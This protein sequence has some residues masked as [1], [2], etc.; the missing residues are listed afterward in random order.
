MFTILETDEDEPSDDSSTEWLGDVGGCS[1]EQVRSQVD[2]GHDIAARLKKSRAFHGSPLD[3]MLTEKAMNKAVKW[4]DC[5]EDAEQRADM[6]TQRAIEWAQRIEAEALAKA[7]G[8]PWRRDKGSTS[9]FRGPP[10][11]SAD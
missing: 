9:H 4:A 8:V 3:E 1:E 11:G 7:A 10:R 6:P 2:N 5:M